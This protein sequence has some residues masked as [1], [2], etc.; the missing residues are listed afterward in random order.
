MQEE[1]TRRK[2]TPRLPWNVKPKKDRNLREQLMPAEKPAQEISP[3]KV[4]RRAMQENLRELHK[5]LPT[6]HDLREKRIFAAAFSVDPDF[7]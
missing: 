3:L 7:E 5:P 2:P 4:D 1:P 6:V